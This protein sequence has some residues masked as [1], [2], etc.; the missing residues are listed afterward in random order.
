V[1]DYN[2]KSRKPENLGERLH[3]WGEWG[4]LY[5]SWGI[6]FIFRDDMEREVNFSRSA[7]LPLI[8]GSGY[9]DDQ[10]K[11]R[12]STPGERHRVTGD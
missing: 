8:F 3:P 2:W 6:N 5:R 9:F 12:F 1:E 4:L 10:Q 11:K 7:R